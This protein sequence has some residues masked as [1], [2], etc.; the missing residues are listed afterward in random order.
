VKCLVSILIPAFNSGEWI[1]DT[2]RSALAQTWP[3]KEI[4]VVDDGSTDGTLAIARRFRSR[5]VS[6][7]SQPKQG[8]AAARNTAL[9]LSQ[10]D[11]IQWL[12]AD[13]LLAPDKIAR[14]LDASVRASSARTLLSSPWGRFFYR[15]ARARFT[16]SPLWCNLSPVEWLVRK[17][18]HNAFMQTATWL[19]SRELTD[20]GGLWDTRLSYDDDG[21]YFARVVAASEAVRFV[22][23]ACVMYRM[24][25]VGRLSDID[26]D[27]KLESLLLSMRL[28]VQHLRRLED[29]ERVRAACFDFLQRNLIHFYP[30]RPDLVA[31]LQD[32]AAGVG[33]HLDAPRLPAKY[34]WIRKALGWEAAKRARSLAPGIRWFMVRRWDKTLANLEGRPP[35]LR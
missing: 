27:D 16:G 17:L 7:V 30:Q 15:P 20:A 6:V 14:Q 4:I 5:E 34:E 21:E 9:S 29:S 3:R 13:D 8:A 11:V 18:Q 33:Q 31:E 10:G 35:L 22:P 1:A 23:G 32:L 26:G 28:H 24:P 19:V 12:D 2:L 25:G